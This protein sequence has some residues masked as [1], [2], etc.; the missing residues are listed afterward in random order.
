MNARLMGKQTGRQ[1]SRI[2]VDQSPFV[3]AAVVRLVVLEAKVGDMIA[4]LNR[5]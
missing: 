5:K 4:Q 2:L 3:D 1:L